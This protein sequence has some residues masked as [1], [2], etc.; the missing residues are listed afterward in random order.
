L[1]FAGFQFIFSGI[2]RN[3]TM[4]KILH[5]KSSEY[6]YWAKLSSSASFN[7]AGS[8]MLHFPLKELPIR[9]ED[10]EI[11]GPG[12]YGFEPLKQAL[13]TR[14]KVSPD[15]VVT[16][17]GASMANH[18]AMAAILE[19][20]DEV[21]IEHPVYEPLLAVAQYLGARVKSLQRT[22]ENGFQIDL[23]IIKRELSSK[24]KLI[25]LS[26]LH[27]PSSVLTSNETL[28]RLQ[29]LVAETGGHVLVD[30]VYLD[31]TFEQPQSTSFH[32]GPEFIVTNS[33]T[34]VYGLS[35]L[36]CGWILANPKLA[37]KMWLLDDLFAGSPVHIAQQLSVIAL[38][39]LDQIKHRSQFLLNK[40]RP[41]LDQFLDSRNDLDT[42]RTKCGTTSFPRWKGGDA[43]KL[44]TLLRHKYETSV[45]PGKFFGMA[46]HFR[47]GICCETEILREGLQRLGFALDELNP[48]I[49]M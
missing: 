23:Q 34:K 47:I 43:E 25:V 37:K 39:H 35:G 46:N 12:G 29:E 30:E 26:N 13:A 38:T 4:T 49:D 7:L 1:R 8:G 17:A 31:A 6:L 9:L 15:N 41:I 10:L 16:A 3:K 45:V 32:L 14:Q 19:P 24:T 11:T 18:L 28:K 21:L 22:F 36:R 33:L 44:C 48:T 5:T 2:D 27:N 40:N 20:G 42:V